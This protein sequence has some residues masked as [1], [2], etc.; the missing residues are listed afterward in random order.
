MRM[1]GMFH[2][3]PE[4]CIDQAQKNTSAG[5]FANALLKDVPAVWAS[6]RCGLQAILGGDPLG[7]RRIWHK[8]AGRPTIGR[9]SAD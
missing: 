1:R 5:K 4:V 8:H 7:C 9:F 6:E 3:L 2:V